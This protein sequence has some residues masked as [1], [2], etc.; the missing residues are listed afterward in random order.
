[1][2]VKTNNALETIELGKKVGS[3][4]KEGDVLLLVGDLGAGKTTLTKGIGISFGIK[5]VINSPTFTICKEYQGKYKLNHL[6]LYRLDGINQDFDL[7]EYFNNKS[8]VV[9][10]WPLNIK[11]ILPD[12]Y[13][14]IGIYNIDENSRKIVINGVGDRYQQLVGELECII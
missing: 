14:E 7:E 11:E 9:I 12:K 8:V 5:R 4:L 3:L 2:E 1:M 10:E 6:D 13:L